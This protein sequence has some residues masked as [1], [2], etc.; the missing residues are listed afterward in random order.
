[1]LGFNPDNIQKILPQLRAAALY[2]HTA[3]VL[4]ES[5]FNSYAIRCLGYITTA[6][7]ASKQTSVGNLLLKGSNSIAFEGII[8]A[9]FVERK[10]N[11]GIAELEAEMAFIYGTSDIDYSSL[12][13]FILRNL[14]PQLMPNVFWVLS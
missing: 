5:E 11:Q 4:E 1:M 3:K 9:T 13:Y 10:I 14:D 12:K 6:L 2:K 7:E 8:K